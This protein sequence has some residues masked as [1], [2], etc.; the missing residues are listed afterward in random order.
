MLKVMHICIAPHLLWIERENLEGPSL[1]RVWQ[2]LPVA[3]IGPGAAASFLLRR[4]AAHSQL[5]LSPVTHL[6]SAAGA[7]S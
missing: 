6:R 4:H 1:L 2:A 3:V 7:N 5:R